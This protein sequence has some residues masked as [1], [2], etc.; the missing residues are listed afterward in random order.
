MAGRPRLDL[1]VCL[2]GS[3]RIFRVAAGGFRLMGGMGMVLGLE[4][5][6]WCAFAAAGHGYLQS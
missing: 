4:V 3:L 5:F 6:G 1:A 2:D